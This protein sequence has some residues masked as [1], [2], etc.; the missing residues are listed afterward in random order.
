[1]NAHR[2]GDTTSKCHML[3]VPCDKQHLFTAETPMS[4][5]EKILAVSCVNPDE[6]A[7]QAYE[8]VISE[9][10]AYRRDLAVNASV[11][12]LFGDNKS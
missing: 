9:V 12:S 7:E 10:S 6:T 8:R 4:N 11:E 5:G 3:I 2:I 1:M